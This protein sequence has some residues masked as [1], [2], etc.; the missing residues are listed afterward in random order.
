MRNS[1]YC[2]S[3]HPHRWTSALGAIAPEPEPPHWLHRRRPGRRHRGNDEPL[4]AGS[5]ALPERLHGPVVDGALSTDLAVPTGVGRECPPG[6]IF[7]E[8][9][10]DQW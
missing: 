10:F 1:N 9:V 6:P 5:P 4:A 8:H 3:L 7:F 2:S